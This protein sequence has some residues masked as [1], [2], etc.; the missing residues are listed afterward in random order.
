ML[1]SVLHLTVQSHLINQLNSDV[2]LIRYEIKFVK[3]QSNWISHQKFKIW[4]LYIQ[5]SQI[6]QTSLIGTKGQVI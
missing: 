2:L 4:L 1:E 5:F 6:V 3:T